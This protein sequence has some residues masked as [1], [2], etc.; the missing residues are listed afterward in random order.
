MAP[1]ETELKQVTLIG[2]MATTELLK[3]QAPPHS[4]AFRAALPAVRVQVAAAPSTKP[5][6][7]PETR[8]ARTAMPSPPVQPTG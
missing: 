8:S 6:L 4:V 2:A 1:K 5:A 7:P 3:L